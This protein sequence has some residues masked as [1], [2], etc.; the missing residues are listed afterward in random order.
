VTDP[1]ATLGVPAATVRRWADSVL[2]GEGA[3][4]ATL[5][6]TFLGGPKMRGLN[7]RALGRD[8]ATDVIAFRLS[9]LGQLAGDIYIC[10]SVA[11]RTAREAGVTEREET[12]RLVVHGVLHVLGQDHP[13]GAGRTRS[14]MWRLQERYVKRLTRGSSP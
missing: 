8:R 1:D 5:S 9:H 13:D 3:G 11:R 7:R 4:Q 12:L 6:I 14:A 10:P 2:D